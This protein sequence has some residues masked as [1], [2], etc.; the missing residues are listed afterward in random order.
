MR[1]ILR[2]TIGILIIV[3]LSP[4]IIVWD[5]LWIIMLPIIMFFGWLYS[6]ECRNTT[7]KELIIEVYKW[8]FTEHLDTIEL[9]QVL[10]RNLF[11]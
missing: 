10:Y 3:I 8:F 4:L 1:K 2:N 7:Y 6:H 5:I 9:F 11:K